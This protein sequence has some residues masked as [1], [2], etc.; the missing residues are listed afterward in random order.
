M[1]RKC[2]KRCPVGAS[3]GLA[4]DA[5]QSLS[6]K[7]H[8]TRSSPSPKLN[9]QL[10]AHSQTLN[11]SAK[12]EL[13]KVELEPEAERK[14]VQIGVAQMGVSGLGFVGVKVAWAHL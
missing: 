8:Q 5:A 12:A 7:L 6:L 2:A 9:S 3:L 13:P 11:C 4:N 14:P 10:T 1:R